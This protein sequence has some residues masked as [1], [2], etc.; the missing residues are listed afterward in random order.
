LAQDLIFSGLNAT[1][2]T[3]ALYR[4]A[5]QKIPF[6]GETW[7][8]MLNPINRW[9]F[10]KITPGLIVEGAVRN[11]ERMNA[12]HPDIPHSKLIRDV[13]TDINTYYGNMGRQGVF[14]NP[15]FR[16]LAQIFLLAPQWIEGL[17]GKETRFL[18]RVTGISNLTGR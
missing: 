2:I 3:D 12:A 14:K 18:G 10:D 13:V 4:D 15:V 9:T 16:D 1:R 7:H 8:K 11:F 5:V 6:I 17:I